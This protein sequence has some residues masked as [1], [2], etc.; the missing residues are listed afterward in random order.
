MFKISETKVKIKDVSIEDT[1]EKMFKRLDENFSNV[2]PFAE[3]TIERWN[4][5]NQLSGMQKNKQFN[6]SVVDQVQT[7]IKDKHVFS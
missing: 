7:I 5:R 4:S 3:E 2:L 1:N 6:K